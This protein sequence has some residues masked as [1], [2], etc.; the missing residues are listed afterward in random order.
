MQV[1]E[2]VRHA[3]LAGQIAVPRN[4]IA[5]E[6]WTQEPGFPAREPPELQTSP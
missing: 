3:C 2:T 5:G 4:V 1:G 6:E